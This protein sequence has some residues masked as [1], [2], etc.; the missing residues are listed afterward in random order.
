MSKERELKYWLL[1]LKEGSIAHSHL[2]LSVERS[3]AFDQLMEAGIIGWFRRGSRSTLRL[4]ERELFRQYIAQH[5]PD[6]EAGGQGAS[7]AQ[8]D[9]G[10]KAS[11]KAGP[12]VV[13]LRGQGT[14]WL[15]EAEHKVELG[16]PTDHFGCFA[17]V[18]PRI[19]TPMPCCIVENLD[20]FLRAEEVLGPDMVFIHPYG[21]LGKDSLPGLEVETLW[22]F[23][24]YDFV[25]LDDYLNLK[26]LYP[27]AQ[28]YVPED[29]ESLWQKY[30][31]PL[32]AGSV[33]R[34]QVLASELPEVERVLRLLSTTQRFLEQ[35][36]LFPNSSATP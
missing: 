35:Q 30:A 16:L 2:P 36:L 3:P 7:K 32:N 13:L 23:C 25:G 29:L 4:L 20:C 9:Q 10:S 28:L 21:R 31:R 34:R 27:Q 22:H 8:R 33:P 17:A 12:K 11:A 18:R 15:N 26:A 19:R 14:I 6:Y 5:Y 24:D 1:L